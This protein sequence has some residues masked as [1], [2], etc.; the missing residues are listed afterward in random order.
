MAVDFA[1]A[2][3]EW[4]GGTITLLELTKQ[5][6]GIDPAD[7][8]RDD[9]LSLYLD[10]AGTS[11]EQY[12]DNKIV[13]QPV[14]EN[15]SRSRSPVDLRFYPATD[16]TEVLIDGEDDTADFEVFSSDGIVWTASSRCDV[17]QECCFKQMSISYTAG[18][19]P[20]PSN[21]GY[22][23]SLTASNFE[24]G[25]VTAGAVKKQT[26]VGVGS[27]EYATAADQESSG[28]VGPISAGS[29]QVLD[30]YRRWHA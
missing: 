21:L 14:T 5:I 29:T 8:S 17:S 13:A 26:V 16:L 3:V 11:C 6:L 23:I 9:E 7:T 27:V 10:M 18:Y 20:I 4:A 19:D 25:S 15:F 30:M 1:N 12:I 22:V 28:S 2:N 24:S